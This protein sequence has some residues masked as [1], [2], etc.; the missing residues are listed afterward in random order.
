[1][2]KSLP[3][4]L[5]DLSILTSYMKCQ[6]PPHGM[7]GTLDRLLA[8]APSISLR[9]MARYT[10]VWL[11]SS[12]RRMTRVSLKKIDVSSVN[13]VASLGTL[14]GR[15]IGPV[16]RQASENCEGSC[17]SP[18]LPLTPPVR[19]WLGTFDDGLARFARQVPSGRLGTCLLYTS[20]SPRD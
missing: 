17:A 5:I 8:G 19:A 1:M 3:W 6:R 20:P 4:Y 7:T 18:K 12:H 9:L 11:A 14:S 16:C 10:S 15:V 13:T 2:P